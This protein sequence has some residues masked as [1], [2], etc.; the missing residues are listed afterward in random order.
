VHG[1][2]RRDVPDVR[3]FHV[4]ALLG[5]SHKAPFGDRAGAIAQSDRRTNIDATHFHVPRFVFSE[6]TGGARD[7][8][9][10]GEK[11]R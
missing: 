5:E 8:R 7:Q 10:G 6:C 9:F 11:D 4:R 3:D 2:S 1:A